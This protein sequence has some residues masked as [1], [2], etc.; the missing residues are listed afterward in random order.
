MDDQ[1]TPIGEKSTLYKWFR[2]LIRFALALNGCNSDNPRVGFFQLL[3]EHCYTIPDANTAEL[4]CSTI[5]IS[6][7]GMA[8]PA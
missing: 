2:L 3:A 6:L 4:M 8:K 1:R 7:G 5:N